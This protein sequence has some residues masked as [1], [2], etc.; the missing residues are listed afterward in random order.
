[1]DHVLHIG[2][3]YQ[4]HVLKKLH[5]KDLTTLSGEKIIKH[6]EVSVMRST[7]RGRDHGNI[8]LENIFFGSK[9]CTDF[10][11]HRMQEC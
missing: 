10:E 8:K 3:H 4:S 6:L 7:A 5:H 2:E 11:N 1:M 9:F